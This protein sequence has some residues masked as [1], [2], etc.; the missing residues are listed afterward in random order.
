MH[1]SNPLIRCYWTF[2]PWLVNLGFPR[3]LL[4]L[5]FR[6]INIKFLHQGTFKYFGSWNCCKIYQKVLCVPFVIYYKMVSILASS[7]QSAN[8]W[9]TLMITRM[10]RV[11]SPKMRNK[12]GSCYTELQ[13][14]AILFILNK[15]ML[16][17]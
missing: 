12:N 13:A 8:M 1:T 10:K 9:A 16:H 14:Y 3:Y 5:S 11:A 7:I 6:T 17:L 4:F 2:L 15:T